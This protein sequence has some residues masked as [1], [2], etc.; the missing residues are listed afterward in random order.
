VVKC[1]SERY[2][3]QG[4]IVPLTRKQ[5]VTHGRY[6]VCYKPL[7][8]NVC[9]KPPF[10]AKG[11]LNLVRIGRVCERISIERQ[12]YFYKFFSSFIEQVSS[13]K[14][15]PQAP[16]SREAILKSLIKNVLAAV[17]QRAQLL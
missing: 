4:L 17:E 8:S 5:H 12:Q 16:H 1:C 3:R 2:L 6:P 13:P 9:Y 14:N 10:P 7:S 15:I 11:T